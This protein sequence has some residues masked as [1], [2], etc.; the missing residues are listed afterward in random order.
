MPVNTLDRFGTY[1]RYNPYKY[2]FFYDAS[3]EEAVYDAEF[4]HLHYNF[5]V[6][7]P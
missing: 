1:V 5:E 7:I 4:A 6:T 3:T 2:G